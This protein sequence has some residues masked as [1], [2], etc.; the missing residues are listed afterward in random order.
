MSFFARPHYSSDTTDFINKLKVDHPTLEQEQRQGRSLLWDKQIDRSFQAA[1]ESAKVA[2]QPY[3][4]Q[5]G[6]DHA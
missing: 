1:A 4:Y 2:Q 5:T 3:V 6:S